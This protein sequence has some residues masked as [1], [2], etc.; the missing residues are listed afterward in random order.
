[1]GICFLLI[2]ITMSTTTCGYPLQLISAPQL[3]NLNEFSGS[4]QILIFSLSGLVSGPSLVKEYHHVDRYWFILYT[5]I[6]AYLVSSKSR[7]WNP[8]HRALRREK[9]PPP[10]PVL[11]VHLR[12]DQ[13]ASNL[14]QWSRIS[15]MQGE[16]AFMSLN[17]ITWLSGL[18][19]ANGQNL[20][21]S[22]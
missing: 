4:S 19:P 18:F 6:F 20:F 7:C 1:M 11:L 22:C 9:Q 14:Q 17:S 2:I 5:Y 10:K 13:T 15:S 21:L 16:G 3:W 8:K 12:R